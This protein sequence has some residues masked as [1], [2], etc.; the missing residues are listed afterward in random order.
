MTASSE[1]SPAAAETLASCKMSRKPREETF[2]FDDG[3]VR[4]EDH[5][6]AMVFTGVRHFRH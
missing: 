3:A 1:M 5:G 6:I 2:A 4:N